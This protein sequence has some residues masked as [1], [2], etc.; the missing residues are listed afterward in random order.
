[1]TPDAVPT[2]AEPATTLH[3][4]ER[5]P[6]IDRAVEWG[7]ELTDEEAVERRKRGLDIVVRGPSERANRARARAI[8]ERVGGSVVLCAPH[9]GRMALPHFHQESRS[10]E[11]H[12]FFEAGRRKARRKRS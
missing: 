1:M 6:G 8:E 5:D 9:V 2:P 10:P 12:P 3:A 7:E 11:G 4:A